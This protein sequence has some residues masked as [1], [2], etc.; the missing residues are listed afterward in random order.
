MTIDKSPWILY[1][2]SVRKRR[3][4]ELLEETRTF[5]SKMEITKV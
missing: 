4:R 3:D 1:Y 2:K 5:P